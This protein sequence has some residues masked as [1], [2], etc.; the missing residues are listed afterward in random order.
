[1]TLMHVFKAELKWASNQNPEDS[2]RKHYSK[3]HQI[4]IEGKPVLNVSAAKAFKA[5]R[6]YTIR[7]IYY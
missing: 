1:M 4:K 6:N 2:T 5:I 7:K 3:T